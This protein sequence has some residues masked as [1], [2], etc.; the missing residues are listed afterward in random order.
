M[1]KLFGAKLIDINM[2]SEEFQYNFLKAVRDCSNIR[3]TDGKFETK[4][5]M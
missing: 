5:L 3:D 1:D 4:M 2:W